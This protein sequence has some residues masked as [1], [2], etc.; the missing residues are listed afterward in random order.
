MADHGKLIIAIGS[1][2]AGFVL[3]EE[4]KS[5]LS[6]QGY[7]VVDCGTNSKD[8][9]DYPIFAK[10]VADLVSSSSAQFGIIVDGAGIGSAMVANKIKNVRAALCYDITTAKNA[11]EHNNANVLT[12]GAGQI[13]S[14][15]AAQIVD[16][17][18]TTEC[19]VERHLRRVKMI[20]DL[21]RGKTISTAT[22]ST[23]PSIP[24]GA[25]LSEL[26]AKQIDRLA[27]RVLDRM[28]A[29]GIDATAFSAAICGDQVC[30]N[31]GHC[32]DKTP[33]HVRQIIQHGADRISY[34]PG[35]GQVPRDIAKYIDHTLLKPD[36]TE[37]DIR[38]LCA[39]AREYEFASVCINP[40]Y[41][42]LARDELKA[43][44]VK[45]CTVVG[46]PLGTHTS[47]VKSLEARKAIRQGAKEIDMVI[48]I[49]AL[50]SG[51]DDLVY[52][53]IR[54]VVEA[55][56]EGGALSKVIIETALLTDDEKVRAC[57]LAKRAYADYVK[58]STGFASGG[59]TAADV[60]LMSKVVAG[61]GMGVKASGG[62]RTRDDAEKMIAAG[63]T[64]IG[65]SAGVKIVQ[66]TL[67]AVTN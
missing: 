15:L 19:T 59:A 32:A 10:A 31:C 53:D 27:E 11:R 67:E 40:T 37:D 50:K 13:G 5:V 12:L 33:D 46:F 2:H 65:A 51:N 29:E 45:V 30:T 49:G 17:F 44:P 57:E 21:D 42:A 18:L 64:R 22:P 28:A 6:T 36:A 16:A 62:I 8:P 55:C 9:V 47:D 63:A 52:K 61:S 7:K 34:I 23:A 20:D 38:K 35:E 41:V 39:E 24:P 56:K 43:T 14:A 1:D 25:K 26:S 58:T 48:N 54:Y 3:K 66:E 60:A 4:L